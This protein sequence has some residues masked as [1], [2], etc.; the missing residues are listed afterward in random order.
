MKDFGPVPTAIQ[1]A[2]DVRDHGS[3]HGN[4]HRLFHSLQ[5]TT[6]GGQEHLPPVNALSMAMNHSQYWHL[7]IF[8]LES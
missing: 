8:L 3:H 6:K 7:P 2:S 1:G 4:I 5:S